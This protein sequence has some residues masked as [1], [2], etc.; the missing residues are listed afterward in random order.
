MSQQQ[1]H[2]ILIAATA[3]AK[4]LSIDELDTSKESAGLLIG[5][6]DKN[7]DNLIITDIDTGKQHQTSA[8]VVLDDIALV[9]MVSKLNERGTGETILGWW[10]THPGY[11]CFLSGTDKNTQQIYQN[12]FPRAIALVVDP[13]KYY[14]SRERADL[15]MQFFRMTDEFNY[16]PLS[17]GIYFDEIANHITN[18][19]NRES[20][21]EIPQLSERQVKELH[22]KIKGTPSSILPVHDK[23]L[24]HGFVDILNKATI[25][26]STGTK[27]PITN[28][29][30][31]KLN[32]I[33]KLLDRQFQEN[34]NKFYSIINIISV[35]IIFVA[36]LLFVFLI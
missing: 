13:I 29:I 21:W 17:F 34:T 24:L 8:Y 16:K 14:R 10:H 31:N 35:V 28:E 25:E 32:Q 27:P 18:L 3:I 12:L 33:E 1:T 26:Q 15:D 30:Q 19:S 9:E 22:N 4:I 2:E 36:W 6:I 11:G 23:T 5:Y 7:N 20:T